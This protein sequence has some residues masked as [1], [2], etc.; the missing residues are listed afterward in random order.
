MHGAFSAMEQYFSPTL[1]VSAQQPLELGPA[2]QQ[3]S[4]PHEAPHFLSQHLRLYG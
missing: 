4:A 1:T 3:S 2:F